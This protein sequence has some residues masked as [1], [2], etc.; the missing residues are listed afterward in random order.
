MY[1]EHPYFLIGSLK[2]E[3]SYNS[4]GRFT[5]GEGGSAQHSPLGA[6]MD[7]LQQHKWQSAVRGCSSLADQNANHGRFPG[8]VWFIAL[9]I[10][11]CTS[12]R[13]A[14]AVLILDLAP[15]N[16]F[17]LR[18]LNSLGAVSLCYSCKDFSWGSES[19]I[20][21]LPALGWWSVCGCICREPLWWAA[22]GVK[23]GGESYCRVV[24]KIIWDMAGLSRGKAQGKSDGEK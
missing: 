20:N 16:L 3:A 6:V 14:R 18:V 2:C 22:R 10:W 13:A 19:L 5:A 15:P 17:I 11:G 4:A 24:S 8:A 12:S 1:L 7:L 9:Q 21:L 23:G